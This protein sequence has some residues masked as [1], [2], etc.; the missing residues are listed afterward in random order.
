[1]LLE[2]ARENPKLR[3]FVQIS[4]DEVYG[5]VPEDRAAR[6]TSCGRAT[7]IREQGGADRLAYSYWRPTTSR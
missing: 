6:P 4:T 3:R 7:R 5:S 1:M 2:A